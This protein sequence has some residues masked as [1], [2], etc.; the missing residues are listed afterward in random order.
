MTH[1]LDRLVK[2]A[3]PHFPALADF[4]DLL[5]GYSAYATVMRY[6]DTDDPTLEETSA[7]YETVKRLRELVNTL[8]PPEE[9]PHQPA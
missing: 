9:P 5:P 3:V 1:D 6:D 7:A 2:L 8:L 4:K